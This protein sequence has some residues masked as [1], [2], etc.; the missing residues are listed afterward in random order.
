MANDRTQ[1]GRYTPDAEVKPTVRGFDPERALNLHNKLF[2]ALHELEEGGILHIGEST[3]ETPL[4]HASIQTVLISPVTSTLNETQLEWFMSDVILNI[5]VTP[6]FKTRFAPSGTLS[7]DSALRYPKMRFDNVPGFEIATDGGY[8]EIAM[9]KG[10]RDRG[11][12]I[13]VN[14]SN[15]DIPYVG[16]T[17]EQ[18]RKWAHMMADRLDLLAAQT[19]KPPL[20]I[21]RRTEIRVLPDPRLA[22]FVAELI[23]GRMESRYN[24]ELP[25]YLHTLDHALTHGQLRQLKND[26]D[27]FFRVYEFEKGSAKF[28]ADIDKLEHPQQAAVLGK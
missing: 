22:D 7:K 20:D 26:P 11:R 5:G 13:I 2:T 12:Q 4:P 17:V 10:Y 15:S 27:E 18:Y 28:W 24:G 9:R 23:R 6:D 14:S 3:Q 19:G 21:V 16:E 1:P 8:I 25:T